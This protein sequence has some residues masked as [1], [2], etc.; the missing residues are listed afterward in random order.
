MKLALAIQVALL[1][2]GPALAKGDEET[3]A[4]I[5]DEL[6]FDGFKS[7]L[8]QQTIRVVRAK[9]LPQLV[10]FL[11]TLAASNDVEADEAAHWLDLYSCCSRKA[12]SPRLLQ[13]APNHILRAVVEK[14]IAG[15]ESSAGEWTKCKGDPLHWS[16]AVE[17]A[18]DKYQWQLAQHLIEAAQRKKHFDNFWV[19]FIKHF[20]ARHACYVDEMQLPKAGV[21]YSALA[22]I[23]GLCSQWTRS[24]HRPVHGA[25]QRLRAS[26]LEVGGQHDQSIGIL[27][28]LLGGSDDL[29][30]NLEI[31]RCLCKKGEYLA[32]IQA[33]DRSIFAH[34]A[35]KLC[36]EA[37]TKVEGTLKSPDAKKG[38]NT[39]LAALTL[40]DLSAVM[41][42]T[43]INFFL[44]SGTLL[45]YAREGGLLAHDKDIDVGI[46]GW[47]QQFALCDALQRDGRF[48]I[49]PEFL[50][51][52]T[53]FYIPIRHKLT[54]IWVDIF[55]Y[56]ETETHLTTGVD[57][58]FG[59]KQRFAFSKFGLKR[60]EFLGA[61]M[62]VP[63]DVDKNLTENF[64]DW[65]QPDPGYISHMESPS[66]LDKGGLDYMLTARL[67]AL[68]ALT[69]KK[70]QQL[71]R[72]ISIMERY[73]DRPGAMSDAIRAQLLQSAER[74][75]SSSNQPLLMSSIP[76]RDEVPA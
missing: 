23:F 63:D 1:R 25:V 47:E 8:S 68:S 72:V 76:N 49:F 45:G 36:A 21:D 5:L 50:Q 58:F 17:L 19:K 60:V 55:V 16:D 27:Q 40:R 41:D 22:S 9:N 75:E 69:K 3:I 44:V 64:G 18:L 67:T 4:K 35:P 6:G 57:F 24:R 61:S 7:L 56:H 66:T 28:T 48:A 42:G 20:S 15:Q 46:V 70:P 12:L 65:Q 37:L 10:I 14:L 38:F 74:M 54:G 71:R 73:G 2:L 11:S 43:A 32:S 34:N 39:K 62:Y 53:T 31:A 29:E 30:V 13:R 26:I 59:H 51:G 52:P 33:L